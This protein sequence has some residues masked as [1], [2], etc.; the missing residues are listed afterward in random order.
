M[1]VCMSVC[2]YVWMSG[3]VSHV[4]M[5]RLHRLNRLYHRLCRLY[6]MCRMCRM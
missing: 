6:R 3:C 1:R 5:C 2:L 4:C